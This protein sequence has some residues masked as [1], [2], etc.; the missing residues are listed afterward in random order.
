[1]QSD[2]LEQPWRWYRVGALAIVATAMALCAAAVWFGRERGNDA[3]LYFYPAGDRGHPG[4]V[5]V[6]TAVG[7]YSIAMTGALL[8]LSVTRHDLRR[9]W[10]GLAALFAFVAAD[11]LLQLHGLLPL[12]D[13]VAR[14]VYWGGFYL[15]VRRLAPV[16]SGRQGRGF[17]VLGAILLALSE[18]VD[19]YPPGDDPSYRFHDVV[20][21]IEESA[22]TIG[23]WTLAVAFLGFAL[24]ELKPLPVTTDEAAAP[25]P[26]HPG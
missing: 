25:V 3:L 9:G 4:L 2:S 10:V 1:M 12:G 8:S 14:I 16:L 26:L 23:A 6:A 17:L 11:G 13:L 22:L 5:A 24:T 20:A 15:V 19:L 21:V 7:F 18:L